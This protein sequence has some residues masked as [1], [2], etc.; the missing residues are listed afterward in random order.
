MKNTINRDVINSVKQYLRSL[1]N[2]G[3]DVRQAIIFGSQVTGKTHPWSDIDLV[4]VSPQ[5]DKKNCRNDIHL[6]WRVAIRVDSR[7]EPI[8]CGVIQWEKD[9]SNAIIDIARREGKSFAV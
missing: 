3:L 5:F 1:K 4:V 9:D 2:R 8:P 6:L 7:I